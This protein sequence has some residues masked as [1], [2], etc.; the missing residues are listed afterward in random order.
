MEAFDLRGDFLIEEEDELRLLSTL[1]ERTV[2]AA[3]AEVCFFIFLPPVLVIEHLD[4]LQQGQFKYMYPA[5]PKINIPKA[6]S[7]LRLPIKEASSSLS[8]V[9]AKA[10]EAHAAKIMNKA[11]I[12]VIVGL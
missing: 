8:K 12:V 9:M 4:P 1:A 10:E 11:V 3:A 2:A 7:K 5:I 6:T